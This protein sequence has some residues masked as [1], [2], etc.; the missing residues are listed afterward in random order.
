LPNFWG[1]KQPP[2][3]SIHTKP[4]TH[5][6]TVEGISPNRLDQACPRHQGQLNSPSNTV[7][8]SLQTQKQKVTPLR[9]CIF[10]KKYNVICI[11]KKQGY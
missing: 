1:T 11:W 10:K 6:H 9:T 2:T 7:Y 4:H 3:H 5:T 8:A